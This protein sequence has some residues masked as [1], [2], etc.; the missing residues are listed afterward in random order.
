MSSVPRLLFLTGLLLLAGCAPAEEPGGQ[1]PHLI[2]LLT[3]DQRWDAL[4][5]AGNPYIQT[6]H[7]D[8]LA[9]DGVRFTRAYVTTPICSISRASLFSGQYARRHGI[10]DFAT[11]FT[12]SAWAQTYPALLRQAGYWTGFV[13]KFGVGREMPEEAF[14]VWHGLPGQ[15]HYEQTDVAGRPVHLT[16]LI[17][18]QAAAFLREAPPGR[19]FA[20]SVSFK[21]PHV[22]DGDPRQFIYDPAYDGLY[23]DVTIPSPETATPAHFERLPAFLREGTEA[24]ERWKLRFS[25]PEQTQRS[26]KGYYRLV[27]GIDAVVGRLRHV[28]DSLGLADQ[29]VIV[30]TS[31]NGFFLGEHGLAGKW[32]GYQP[33]VRVPL[34]VYDPRRPAPPQDRIRHEMVLNIDLAPTLLDLAAV[35]VPAGM[36]GRSLRPLIHGETEEAWRTDFFFEHPFDHPGIPRSEGVIGD[37]YTYLY[38]LDQ[39]PPFEMLFDRASD[40]H[41][42]ENLVGD[43]AHEAMLTRLRAR[44]EVLRAAAE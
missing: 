19:P 15:P 20:L 42:T 31:D 28:L 32:Y 2:V 18:E 39:R 10:H 5:A 40:P 7:L 25:N 29:T 34:L 11:G 16:R 41:E 21:A 37:R 9:R 33:S 17:G 1:A 6:P 35:P 22:Q 12:D 30:F 38:Y 24:R 13:G 3:D 44:Y 26:L 23:A 36:Q 8:A 43:P 4:G 14:D 27:S